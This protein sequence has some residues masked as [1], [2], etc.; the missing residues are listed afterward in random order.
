MKTIKSADEKE[1]EN[2]KSVILGTFTGKCCDGDVF[3][4]ND[5]KLSRELFENLFNSDEYKRAIKNR[6]YIGFLGHPEDPGCQD[7]RNACI[8]M[9]EGKL[10]SN[11]DI[12]GSFDLIDTPVGQV[13]KKF[14]DAGVTF[15]ISIRG[16]GDVDGEG[17]VDPETFVFRG[18]DLVTFPAYDDCVPTFT[19]IAASSDLDKQVKCKSVC[20]SVMKNLPEITSV[21]ALN[22][23]KEQFREGSKEYKAIDE[24]LKALEASS[25][26][27]DDLDISEE[28]VK[29]LTE[30]YVEASAR[31]KELHNENMKL[32]KELKEAKFDA[33]RTQVACSNKINSI[34]R[35]TRAQMSDMNDELNEIKA[36]NTV[37]KA[38]VVKASKEIAAL[39]DELNRVQTSNL[40]YNQKI[41][42]ASKT[43]SQKD[44]TI[45]R[46]EREKNETV[47]RYNDSKEEASNLDETVRSLTQRVEAAEKV[48]LD[49]QEAYAK[50]YANAVGA[51]LSDFSIS[52]ETSVKDL[53]K[54][55]ASKTISSQDANDDKLDQLEVVDAID[56]IVVM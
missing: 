26:I 54:L 17:N 34:K 22:T 20:A 46:L 8:V 42:A 53:Q 5:M 4:N 37:N 55:I 14:I 51:P 36:S 25:N 3:N 7:Y 10:E 50:M 52:T 15:G 43:I 1:N 31:I 2:K 56:D 40:K 29:G 18:F 44:S 13:V 12:T 9:T 35:I 45:S 49:Y 11:G 47:A 23:L 30:L 21:T 24:R 32:K 39:K 48:A 19:E 33:Y 27:D 41:E 38:K 28:K 16:A 6:Y